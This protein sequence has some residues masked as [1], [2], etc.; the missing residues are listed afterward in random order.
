MK[1]LMLLLLLMAGLCFAGQPQTFHADHRADY[2]KLD[3]NIPQE[4]YKNVNLSGEE[5]AWFHLD[6]FGDRYG[7]HGLNFLSLQEVKTSLLGTH[8]H[9]AQKLRGIPVHR[10][11]IIVSVSNETGRVYMVYNNTYPVNDVQKMVSGA[12]LDAEEAYDIAWNDLRVHGN[13]MARPKANL[14]YQPEG[15]HFRLVYKVEFAVEAPFGYWEHTV[16]AKSGSVLDVRRTT[17]SRE[18]EAEVDFKNFKGQVWD[19]AAAEE[20][21]DSRQADRAEEAHR[22]AATN[23]TGQVFDPDPVTALQDSTLSDTSP[24]SAFTGAYVTRTLTDIDVSGGTYRL[25]GPW[26][27]IADFDSPSTAPTTTT[28]GNWNGTRGNQSFND[29]MTYFHV[30]QS[31]RYMQSLGFTGSTGIQYGSITVDADGANGADNSYFQPGNNRMSFGHGCVDDNEDAF[32]ILHEYGHAIHHSINSNWSGGDTGGMGEGFGDYWGGSYR[33]RTAN[34]ASFN[35]AWAFPWDGHNSCWGGRDMDKTNFQYDPS[36]T[37]PA[38]ATVGGVYSDELWSTPLFQALQTLLAQNVAHA[39]V[40]QIVLQAHFGLGSGLSMR[41]MA[42]A[43]VNTA[44]NLFP[45][46]PH[47]DVF[48]DKFEAQ[49]I[50]EGT[51]TPPTGTELSNGETRNNLS[52]AQNSWTYFTIQVPAGATNLAASLSGGSGDADLYTRFNAQPTT[53][54]YACRPYKSGNN[55]SCTEASP[56][57]GTWHIGIRAYSAFSGAS[58]TV[59]YDEP[60]GSCTPGN[61]NQSSLSGSTGSWKHYTID[62]PAC[63]TNLTVTMSGGTGDADLYTRFGAQPTTSAYDC[64]PYAS[65]NSEDCSVSNPQTGIYH[66][67]VRAYSSYSGVNLTISYQ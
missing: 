14:V 34:G 16:D 57:A 28:N 60:G 54:D 66:I 27:T 6:S 33:I 4:A 40:D 24:A 65:G 44:G 53:G 21:Y 49:N 19:R 67:S 17:I 47:K 56:S 62:V 63:A 64:R 48:Q 25:N 46:G 61:N 23:G 3:L 11:E 31:Q 9:F 58:L 41:D 32:V 2:V 42:T 10:A 51:V 37:Y 30:D 26:V 5:L 43:I 12:Q 22:K 52:G 18:R 55:E 15:E 59:S 8:Y 1:K 13:L 36:R 39:E 50:L 35:P 7:L 38:H 29:A 20:I 45:S